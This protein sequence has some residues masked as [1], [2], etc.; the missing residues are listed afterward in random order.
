M[1][2][3]EEE[4]LNRA[5]EMIAGEIERLE[6]SREGVRYMSRKPI[7]AQVNGV[8]SDQRGEKSIGEGTREEIT[9]E[10]EEGERCKI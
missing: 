9:R 10:V 8:K 1:R 6:G 5:I 4:S 2:R 3:V 7:V